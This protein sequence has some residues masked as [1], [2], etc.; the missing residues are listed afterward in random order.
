MRLYFYALLFKK[1]Y[2]SLDDINALVIAHVAGIKTQIVVFRIC[3]IPACVVTIIIASLLVCL[4]DYLDSL[5]YRNTIQIDDI[6]D[7]SFHIRIYE[8]LKHVFSVTENIVS[9]PA[10][11]Y[12]RLSVCKLLYYLRLI[13]EKISVRSKVVIIRVKKLTL[14]NSALIRCKRLHRG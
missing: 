1:L 13:I 4:F 12:R 8:N 2:I 3:P 6:L 9:T 11:Y 5:F 7:R 10:N 14:V